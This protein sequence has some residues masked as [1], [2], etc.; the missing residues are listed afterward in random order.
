IALQAGA[1]GLLC[2]ALWAPTA[3]AY[4][5]YD[6]RSPEHRGC[7]QCHDGFKGGNGLLHFQHNRTVLG[8]KSC[9]A[10]HPDGGGSTPVL[11]YSS[12]PGGGSGCAGCHGQD[13]GETSPNSGLMKA[14]AYG[15]RQFHVNK[16]A[17]TDDPIVQAKLSSCGTSGC[18]RP[19]NLGHSNPF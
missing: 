14:T 5:M 9:N 3:H 1:I 17:T 12:G 18:H 13:Y 6:D 4:P 15:L 11:T 8:I 7:V 19:G 10:C 2:A 16:A